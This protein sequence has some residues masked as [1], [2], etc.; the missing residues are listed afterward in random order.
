MAQS[1]QLSS[2]TTIEL[3]DLKGTCV[4]MLASV[5][6]M[7]AALGKCPEEECRDHAH[8]LA[9]HLH[10]SAGLMFTNL[11]HAEAEKC[12]AQYVSSEFARAGSEATATVRILASGAC[13]KTL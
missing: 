12:L 7:H 6:K 9:A 1:M 3:Q 4:F 11:G 13:C 5:K 8:Q 10:G 2:P